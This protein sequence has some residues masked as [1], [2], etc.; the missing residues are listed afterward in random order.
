VPAPNSGGDGVKSAS[1]DGTTVT[2]P[3]NG[4]T[5]QVMSSNGGVIELAIDIDSLDRGSYD[6]STFFGDIAGRSTTVVSP[7]PVHQFISRGIFIAKTTGIHRV[8][9]VVG[10]IARKTLVIGAKETGQT[11]PTIRNGRGA[12]VVGDAPSSVIST[13]TLKGKFIFSGNKNDV[14]S[15][16]GMIQL[17]SGLAVSSPHEFS[18][19]LGNIVVDTMVDKKGK[20]IITDRL[21]TLKKLKLTYLKVKKDTITKGGEIA[22]VDVTFNTAGMVN[23][24]FDT[25]GIVRSASDAGGGKKAPRQIQIAMLLDGVPYTVLAPVTF[26]VSSNTSFGSI[27]GRSGL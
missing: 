22:R 9:G 27:S 2:N 5:I 19:A 11:V 4:I 16:T 3:I 13:K 20:G 8:T 7:R 6:A 23:A 10:G 17:P 26:T 21:G 24:G 12:R 18:I 1:D 14:V 15:Y 25:E